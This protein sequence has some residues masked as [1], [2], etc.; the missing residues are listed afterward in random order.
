[1]RRHTRIPPS[2]LAALWLSACG[3][4]VTEVW[5]QIEEDASL[6]CIGASHLR[7]QVNLPGQNPNRM[8]FDSFGVY[9]NETTFRCQLTQELRYADLPTGRGL[10]VQMQLSDSSTHMDG[11]L[12]EASSS[13]FD[14]SGGSPVQQVTVPL[15][16]RAGVQQG[17]L[18]VN[19]PLDWGVVANIAVLQFRVIKSADSSTVRAYYISYDPVSRPD[20]FPLAI[21]NLPHPEFAELFMVYL[22]GFDAHNHLLRTW[23]SP[24]YLGGEHTLFSC[25]PQP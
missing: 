23:S 22:E 8:I 12:A 19:K 4:Q 11:V 25:I 21:S 1:M 18:L 7:L 9:F 3:P 10:G 15:F 6:P 17:T 14:V 20:P 5:L 16:R 13:V 24:V 2:W